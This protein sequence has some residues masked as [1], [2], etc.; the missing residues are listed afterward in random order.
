[1][2][3]VKSDRPGVWYVTTAPTGLKVHEF[4]RGLV[5]ML[6]APTA[7]GATISSNRVRIQRAPVAFPAVADLY[8]SQVPGY[9]DGMTED[10]QDRELVY[11][12][13]MQSAKVDDWLEH[14]V[15]GFHDDERTQG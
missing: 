7:S 10:E 5:A 2:R 6:T 14:E 13:A 15:V 4:D 8:R 1:M 11:E 3:F 12:L 9:V